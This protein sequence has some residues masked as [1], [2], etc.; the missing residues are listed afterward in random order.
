VLH[1]RA[2][3][4]GLYGIAGDGSPASALGLTPDGEPLDSGHLFHDGTD[5]ACGL[6]R[7]LV[8]AAEVSHA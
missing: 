3:R 1:G 2:C 6:C 8:A 7:A 5:L 4:F